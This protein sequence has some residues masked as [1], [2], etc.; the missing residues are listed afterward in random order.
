MQKS[1]P[2]RGTSL[3]PETTSVGIQFHVRTRHSDD[4]Y[5]RGHKTSKSNDT[6]IGLIDPQLVQRVQDITQVLHRVQEQGRVLPQRS[7]QEE[8]KGLEPFCFLKKLLGW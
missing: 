7:E 6:R 5:D 1:I 3:Q 4:A 8:E 2:L